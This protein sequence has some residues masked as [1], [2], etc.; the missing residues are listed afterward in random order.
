MLEW[1]GLAAL[2]GAGASDAAEPKVA[3]V[4]ILLLW[5]DSVHEV[6]SRG[7]IWADWQDSQFENVW[8]LWFASRAELD[9]LIAFL[10]KF[11][12]LEVPNPEDKGDGVYVTRWEPEHALYLI[13]PELDRMKSPEGQW[14]QPK[15]R[16]ETRLQQLYIDQRKAMDESDGALFR[17][18]VI[19][20]QTLL[21]RASAE[22]AMGRRAPR[23]YAVETY[24]L[25]GPGWYE[26]RGYK[27]ALPML[28]WGSHVEEPKHRDRRS[29][30][31]RPWGSVDTTFVT[32]P[33]FK[34]DLLA[35]R[36]MWDAS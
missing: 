27:G 15:H 32:V 18:T 23:T 1:L 11:V 8:L 25:F 31:E 2:A 20:L 26:T 30:R 28:A 17:Q 14:I 9:Q 12:A 35:V 3:R 19:G 22:Q 29:R 13:S 7:S 10:D 33:L 24:A 21:K 36:K 6:L 16:S 4:P 34:S 5:S